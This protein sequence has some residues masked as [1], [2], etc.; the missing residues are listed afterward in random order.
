MNTEILTKEKFES[1][2]NL[3]DL[4][5]AIS[6]TKESFQKLE[7]TET[8]YLAEREKKAQANIQKLLDESAELLEKTHHNYEEINTFCNV[9]SSYKDFLDKNYEQFQKMLAQFE[10]RNE[11]WDTRYEGQVKEFS[12]QEAIIKQD[13]EQIKKGKKEIEEANRQIEKDRI[14]LEDRRRTLERSIERLKLNKK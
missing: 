6:E 4:N 11:L 5:V 14:L 12:R 1:I 10:E 7:K 9:V 3:A 8:E 13:A 2:K